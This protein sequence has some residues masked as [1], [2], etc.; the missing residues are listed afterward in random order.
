MHALRAVNYLLLLNSTLPDAVPELIG[1]SI[2]YI[3]IDLTQFELALTVICVPRA[4]AICIANRVCETI[5]RCV[6]FWP[7]AVQQQ[8]YHLSQNSI[9]VAC[10]RVRW[11]RTTVQHDTPSVRWKVGGGR[12]NVNLL[13]TFIYVCGIELLHSNTVGRSTVNRH[14]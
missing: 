2:A 9:S 3:D 4:L 10:V 13:G 6:E 7:Y 5:H 11:T 12:E 1:L 14:F 8:P